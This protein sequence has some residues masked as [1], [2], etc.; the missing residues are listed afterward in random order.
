MKLSQAELN[1][2]KAK[3][4][5]DAQAL[6]EVIPPKF[7]VLYQAN[8]PDSQYELVVNEHGYLVQATDYMTLRYKFD[9][10]VNQF[11]RLLKDQQITD[12]IL[13]D[14]Y[15]KELGKSENHYD[16]LFEV[17]TTLL[18]QESKMSFRYSLS[19]LLNMALAS[20]I[21]AMVVYLTS[22]PAL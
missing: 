13:V 18:K 2:R 5:Q 7:V 8:N 3:L 12:G 20:V 11:D 15:T 16:T 17:Y 6:I 14:F 19:L 1:S 9:S 21:T 4:L 10:I 22:A